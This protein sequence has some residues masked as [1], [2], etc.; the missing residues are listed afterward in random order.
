M[1]VSVSVDFVDHR[2]E[3]L[4]IRMVDAMVSSSL[5]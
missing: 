3:L 4:G 5:I 2:D 1:T